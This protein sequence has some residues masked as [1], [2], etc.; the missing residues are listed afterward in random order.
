[1]KR[2]AAV[3]VLLIAAMCVQACNTTNVR[4]NTYK[5]LGS[6]AVAVET[7]ADLA[8]DPAI[9]AEVV[10]GI[11][12]AKDIASPAVRGLHANLTAYTD[13]QDQID[14]I[15]AAGGE[16][17]EAMLAQVQAALAALQQSRIDTAP[18]IAEL[19]AA[20]NRSF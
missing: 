19:I 17:S 5:M 13:L 6:Y 3:P 7:G 15:R 16:P 18:L 1:M 9:P 14:G 8:E 2:Y 4:K 20:I 12:A 11:K 10:D